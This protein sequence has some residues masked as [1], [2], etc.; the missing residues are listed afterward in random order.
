MVL[1]ELVTGALDSGALAA[2]GGIW[3]LRSGLRPTARLVELVAARLGDLTYPERALLELVTVGEPLGQAELAALA[4]P[5]CV[6]ALERKGLG[7]L[8]QQGLLPV[9]VAAG[10]RARFVERC[11]GQAASQRVPAA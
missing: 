5:A 10:P 1:R 7:G 4:D 6:E 8:I 3:R 2:D 9:Q 11:Q